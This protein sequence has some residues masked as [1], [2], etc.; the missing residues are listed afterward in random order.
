MHTPVKYI[1]FVC[2]TSVNKDSLLIQKK[3]PLPQEKT[4]EKLHRDA[5]GEKSLH[6]GGCI[7]SRS[8][9]QCL[10]IA[11]SK[12]YSI[13]NHCCVLYTVLRLVVI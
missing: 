8:I 6:Y 12:N 1:P 10:Y 5:D 11:I 9:L 2:V 4:D 7:I 3:W 13:C